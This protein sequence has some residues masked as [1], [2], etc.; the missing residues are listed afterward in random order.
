[1][2]GCIGGGVRIGAGT[3]TGIKRVFETGIKRVLEKGIKGNQ[4]LG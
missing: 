1:M 3:E 2:H 4:K